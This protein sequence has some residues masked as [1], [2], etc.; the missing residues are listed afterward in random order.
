MKLAWL[1]ILFLSGF[2]NIKFFSHPKMYFLMMMACYYCTST[3]LT[4]CVHL[5]LQL[6]V[7]CHLRPSGEFCKTES[8]NK[9]FIRKTTSF[10]SG[11]TSADRLTPSHPITN[12]IPSVCPPLLLPG[13]SIFSI[14]PVYLLS[15]P[16]P[17][18]LNLT[19]LTLSP[20]CLTWDVSLI[21]S[22]LL[23]SILI[24]P[25]ENPNPFGS[26]FLCHGLQTIDYSS[27]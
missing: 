5:F 9:L 4:N 2:R 17:K 23:L 6:F 11:L 16:C 15:L 21:Y 24:T 7:S 18:D 3:Y 20:K 25:N 26:A 8:T 10:P 13:S 1:F 14:H 22:F 19:P 27:K 12:I